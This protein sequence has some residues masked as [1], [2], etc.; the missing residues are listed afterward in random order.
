M[1]INKDLDV[2][3]V[4]PLLMV[5][6]FQSDDYETSE[7]FMTNADVPTLAV[8]GII[9]DP[10]NPFTEKMIDSS[11]KNEHP[12]IITTARNYEINSIPKGIILDTAGWKM[13]FRT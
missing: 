10:R 3:A 6:D 2:E 9:R 7:T 12:Q 13:V 8:E 11:E 1:V 4:N 5:K